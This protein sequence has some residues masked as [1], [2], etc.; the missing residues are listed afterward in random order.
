MNE[1]TELEKFLGFP[2]T[3][4][5]G[6]SE[7]MFILYSRYTRYYSCSPEGKIIG[8]NLADNQ[9]KFNDL[10]QKLAELCP[11]LQYL[12]LN[13][14]A[15]SHLDF[16]ASLPSLKVLDLSVGQLESLSFTADFPALEKLDVSRNQLQVFEI[17]QDMPKLFFLD[18][19]YNQI[20]TFHFPR[21]F[22]HLEYCYFFQNKLTEIHFAQ[23]LPKL[24][25]LHLAENQ[26]V[27]IDLP[28]GFREL[29]TL[30]L[31]DNQLN[32]QVDEAFLAKMPNLL[33]LYLNGDKHII[34]NLDRELWVKSES[35]LV[36]IQNYLK[37][38]TPQ[39]R[40][41]YEA[42]L[43]LIGNGLVGKTSISRKLLDRKAP[44]TTLEERT[45][46]LNINVV[47]YWLRA[48]SP[49]Y[50][51][52]SDPIDFRFNIWDFGGQGRYRE[53]QQLFCSRKSLYIFVTSPDDKPENKENPDDYIGEEYWLAMCN[54]YNKEVENDQTIHS[55]ILYVANKIEEGCDFNINEGFIREHRGFKNVR[56]FV[57]ISCYD[58]KTID[59]LEEK[60]LA[61]LKNINADLF[62]EKGLYNP[63]WHRVKD[64]LES[65][66]NENHISLQEYLQ[67]CKDN[68]LDEST[69]FTWLRILDRI[70]TVIYFGQNEKLRDWVILDPLWVKDA[71]CKV[72]DFEFYDEKNPVLLP[73][74]FPKIWQKYTEIERVK[75]KDLLLQFQFCYEEIQDSQIQYIVPALLTA[76]H[77]SFAN[78][79]Y[80]QNSIG[81]IH[82]VYTP[83]LPAG[84]LN[85][86]MVNLHPYIHNNLKWKNGVV[87]QSANNQAFVEITEH[88]RE[89]FVKVCFFGSETE[90]KP[91]KDLIEQTL[92][93]L[94]TAMKESRFLVHLDFETKYIYKETLRSAKDLMDFGVMA[95]ERFL[96]SIL[97][98][99]PLIPIIQPL[100]IT[101]ETLLINP[102]ITMEEKLNSIKS[103]LGQDKIEKALGLLK[104]ICQ[105]TD[106]DNL[107]T[108]KSGEWAGL[109][110][111]ILSSGLTTEQENIRKNRFRNTL[112]SIIDQLKGELSTNRKLK[113]NL[114]RL[115]L[116]ENSEVNNGNSERQINQI[117]FLAANPTNEASLQTDKE[118]RLIRQR[119]QQS[120]YRDNFEVL[121]PSLGLTIEDLI[122]VMNQK[123][124]I[125]HF[126]GHGTHEGIMIT[127]NQNQAVL[128]PTAALQRLFR[129]HH[130]NLKLVVLNSCYSA[131][132]AQVISQFGCYVIG[133]NVPIGDDA[134]ISFAG[135]LYIGLGEG[136]SIEK[137]YDDAMIIIMT[138]FPG[139]SL[140]PEVW[141]EG[142]KLDI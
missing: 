23:A 6:I 58:P 133:M 8:L 21:G 28:S 118:F 106:F 49:Q 121:M 30:Y 41:L 70:G 131:E 20:K 136:K 108:L 34:Q 26:L 88:W 12:N 2:L 103:L 137:A 40:P 22:Q 45:P 32:M 17:Q 36:D 44:L 10:P 93:N 73:K 19:G 81:E 60:I 125:V 9:L 91:L 66:K 142:K 98:N 67:I 15:F 1:I 61:S 94:N 13:R 57:K 141:K 29:E 4:L 132:Q 100:D 85:K 128:M 97:P 101:N 110:N 111:E 139:Y 25:T 105:D 38:L 64:I 78:F 123:P 37:S 59:T 63:N 79:P 99:L 24:N 109:K 47:P 140:V 135:G 62:S 16:S 124:E 56:D 31:Q 130:E 7:P 55:P 119:I 117:L 138:S 27:S 107:I 75:L 112:I 42:K 46:G 134:A 92:Q 122:K 95:N 39:N 96:K 87:L 76:P 129:Q 33:G 71:V 114:Q 11:D 69:A 82:F 43:L 113:E 48:V 90:S 74:F 3:E 72:L 53:V 54:A 80:L 115:N 68:Q 77:P 104:E 102:T 84:T 116:D 18:A 5:Q 127:N 83:F 120:T 50:T 86:L 35:C 52:L 89:G 126:S 65:K 14:N 51:G